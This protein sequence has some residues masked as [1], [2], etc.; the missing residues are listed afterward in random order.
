MSDAKKKGARAAEPT[1]DVT[2]WAAR[3]VAGI[4]PP[5][6]RLP[7]G[8]EKRR[9]AWSATGVEGIAPPGKQQPGEGPAALWAVAKD[10]GVRPSQ[11]AA[12]A[13]AK[14]DAQQAA[15]AARASRTAATAGA[16]GAAAAP[17][18][19]RDLKT[20]LELIA[21]HFRAHPLDEV[22]AG[23]LSQLVVQSHAPYEILVAFTILS[24]WV[25]T[26]AG[27]RKTHQWSLERGAKVFYN[28]AKRLDP[29]VRPPRGLV[30]KSVDPLFYD[31][32]GVA[33]QLPY[34]YATDAFLR[35]LEV[36]RVEQHHDRLMLRL[37]RTLRGRFI[38]GRRFGDRLLD[39]MFPWREPDWAPP[40]DP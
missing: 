27:R 37:A 7:G 3:G 28:L 40:D 33:F 5:G 25:G 16:G 15:Q 14:R 32:P 36:C 23:G 19:P 11:L 8:S 18:D 21:D 24:A 13:R 2:G 30:P 20:Y 26:D 17:G 29:S 10:K 4:V 12:G 35:L 38:D 39:G 6:R 22:A 34:A 9:A 31:L 1:G